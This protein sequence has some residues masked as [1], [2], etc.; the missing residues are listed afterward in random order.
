MS[1]NITVSQRESVFSD[2]PLLYQWAND[3]DTRKASFNPRQI[4]WQEHQ[5]WLSQTLKDPLIHLY[6]VSQNS[7]PVGTYRLH[8][9]NDR[10]FVS[11]S[12]APHSRY[13]GFGALLLGLL[14]KT[15]GS[16]GT[17][18]LIAQVRTDNPASRRLF[19]KCGFKAVDKGVKNS[20][21]F[22][23]FELEVKPR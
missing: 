21:T 16:L 10:A 6:I 22:F 3:P 18:T 15:A 8:I 14:V 7:R 2:A 4:S 1:K 17:K 12:V 20:L 23:R 5:R 13:Q 11:V 9:K 19:E